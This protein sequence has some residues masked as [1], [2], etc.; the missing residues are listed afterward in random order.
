MISERSRDGAKWVLRQF[1]PP[2]FRCYAV[3]SL[4]ARNK[5]LYYSLITRSI[6]LICGILFLEIIFLSQEMPLISDEFSVIQNFIK[7]LWPLPGR[8][9]PNFFQFLVF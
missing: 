1:L 4:Q 5:E 8:N 6:S 2:N 3:R 9:A 7:S